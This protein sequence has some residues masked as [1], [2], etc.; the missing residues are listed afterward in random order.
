[1]AAV[2]AVAALA[3]CPARAGVSDEHAVVEAF[4]A[5]IR[6]M[7]GRADW[8]GLTRTVDELRRKREELGPGV[9]ALHVFYNTLH[10][11]SK[12]APAAD[13]RRLKEDA[14]AWHAAV[15]RE[16]APLLL[17]AW[18]AL[19]VAADLTKRSAASGQGSGPEPWY[20]KKAGKIA[21][22]R[23]ASLAEAGNDLAQA[24]RCPARDPSL[25]GLRIWKAGLEDA[26]RAEVD[27]DFRRAWKIDPEYYTAYVDVANYLQPD[28]HG[29]LGDWQAFVSSICDEMKRDDLF[30]ILF[31]DQVHGM[32]EKPSV[33]I[34]PAEW[35]RIVA[36]FAQLDR[37]YPGSMILANRKAYLAIRAGQPG[38]AK[39]AFAEIGDDWDAWTWGDR[40]AFDQAK[41]KSSAMPNPWLILAGV[42]AG[43]AA[44]LGL[45]SLALWLLAR[46]DDR[47]EGG[48]RA[49]SGE[50]LIGFN[51]QV[52]AVFHIM[53]TNLLL[54][55]ITLGVYAFWGRA[56][57]RRY[58]WSATKFDGDPLAFHGTGLETLKG[59][60]K[61]LLMFGVPYGLLLFL[62]KLAHFGVA[63][64]MLINLGS[65]VIVSL[66]IPFAVVGA[67]R[68]RLTRTSWRGIRFGYTGRPL[69]YAKTFWRESLWLGLTL[70]IRSPWYRA[71]TW[72][73]L[74]S[75]STF[76]SRAFSFSGDPRELLKASLIRTGIWVGL[77]GAP[78]GIAI[79]LV[80]HGHAAAGGVLMLVVMLP[81]IVAFLWVTI[82]YPLV[83]ARWMWAHTRFGSARFEWTPT[84]A[85]FAW[86][87]V[88]NY[89]LLLV[90]L[91][92]GWP[93]TQ[94]RTGRFYAR[95]LRIVG[96]PRLG[97]VRQASA[98][99]L[100]AS[101]AGE[102]YSAMFGLDLDLG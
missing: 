83:V 19:R 49:A 41:R 30:T 53:I 54:T 29:K 94:V 43:Y 68:Y 86:W 57:T 71:A 44:L 74:W 87:Q 58:L 3:A 59:F 77:F 82:W 4:R 67:R 47:R 98:E 64:L 63:S 20:A 80:G 79:G 37:K 96:D 73:H 18:L 26:P 89:F 60:G 40:A 11:S 50:R 21:D 5:R 12:T 28:Q 101:A 55:V 8:A 85:Q 33:R 99:S 66:F 84:W 25:W 91:G 31:F 78:F 62:P 97:T 13:L 51:G 9:S 65:V 35:Q 100:A 102:D 15:P 52:R 88:G 7:R 48:K 45:A 70:G 69:E 22:Q 93:W 10:E 95:H 36:G 1:M 27:A 2:A 42:Y 17:K 23:K 16:P 14:D 81:A 56:R 76:G 90:T 92:L 46:R 34:T 72:G 39:A 61:A 38:V 6:E 24:E 75:R 32:N